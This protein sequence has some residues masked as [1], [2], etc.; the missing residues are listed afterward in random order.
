[1]S[2]IFALQK[3]VL[4]AVFF[5]GMEGYLLLHGKMKVLDSNPKQSKAKNLESQS[6]ES[7]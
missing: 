7:L 1:M 2:G 3:M 4:Q 5:L 6:S